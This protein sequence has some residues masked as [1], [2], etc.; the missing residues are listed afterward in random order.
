MPRAEAIPVCPSRPI[1]AQAQQQRYEIELITPL[2]GGGVVTRE[3]DPAFPIRPTA[4]RGQL[5]F[6]WRATVGAACRTNAELRAAQSAV[7]GDTGCASRVQ[8]HVEVSTVDPPRPCAR[9]E[10]DRKN[11][12]I[13]GSTP[14]WQEPLNKPALPYALFPFQGQLARDRASIDVPPA[15][16]IHKARFQL[17]L[18]WQ[19]DI[20]F[21]RQLEP[22]L[23]AWVHFGGLGSRTRRGCGSICCKRLMARDRDTLIT[24]L[25]AY[26]AQGP[27]RDWPTLADAFLVGPELNNALEAWNQVIALLRDFRQGVGI[28][29]NPG[30]ERR[31]P[32]RS[33]WPEPETIREITNERHSRHPRMA[34]IPNN[35]FPRAAFGLP[36]VF[37]FKDKGDPPDT[38]LYPAA[39]PEGP[40]ERMAS[41]LIIKPVALQNSRFAPIIVHLKSPTLPGVVL[42]EDKQQLSLPSPIVVSGAALVT[43]PDSPMAGRSSNGSAVEAFLAYARAHNFTRVM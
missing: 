6:W 9:F 15:S 1:P 35:A 16:C 41:P 5:Q 29:R 39:G 24:T 43:Y 14:Q 26:R 30:E 42:C 33:R 31:R 8:V 18:S 19:N 17:T 40:R 4:I 32:G 20:D 36:I 7:W 28:G 3:N 11:N 2:F 37:H 13:Y 27:V 21:A 23:W 34:Q 12:S 25:R 38:V 10:R 22:A